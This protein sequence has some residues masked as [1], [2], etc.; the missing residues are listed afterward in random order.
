M[1]A[2]DLMLSICCLL[3]VLLVGNLTQRIFCF[4]QDSQSGI[5]SNCLKGFLGCLLGVVSP[6]IWW[7]H[8]LFAFLS[9]APPV[10]WL[11]IVSVQFDN[12]LPSVSLSATHYLFWYLLLTIYLINHLFKTRSTAFVDRSLN[13]TKQ[14]PYC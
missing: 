7:H 3:F 14:L 11:D 2:L 12:V 4:T 8:F 9:W 1:D 6:L 5:L 10:S 13:C